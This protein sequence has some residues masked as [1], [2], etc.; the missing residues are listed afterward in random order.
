M[1]ILTILRRWRTEIGISIG[2]IALILALGFILPVGFVKQLCASDFMPHGNCYLWKPEILWLHVGSDAVV[3]LSYFAIP[4]CLVLLVKKRK[5]MKF[6]G[7]FWLFSL[8]I[9]FCGLSHLFEIYSVWHGAYRLAGTVKLLTA[10]ASLS[11]AVYLIRSMP[12]LS[13]L[14]LKKEFQAM[15]LQLSEREGL[16]KAILSGG[17]EGFVTI[18]PLRG[19]ND[20]IV[21]FRVD[22]F[23]AIAVQ[24]MQV[25]QNE[26]HGKSID[27][28]FPFAAK[29]GLQRI[30]RECHESKKAFHSEFELEGP[31]GELRWISFKVVPAGP[32][33][34]VCF[35]DV[36]KERQ[37]EKQI[38][39][40][41]EERV[42]RALEERDINEARAQAAMSAAAH[43]I[44]V[45]DSSGRIVQCNKELLTF[46]G[47]T[48][49]ELLGRSV[50]DL[51][52]MNARGRHAGHVHEFDEKPARRPMGGAIQKL[53]GLRK[54]G[55]TFPVEIGLN[56]FET[57][58]GRFVCASVVDI[59]ERI[60]ARAALQESEL[61]LQQA[62]S[63]GN[64][65]VWHWFDVTANEEYWSDKMYEL[66][67]YDREE[68]ESNYENFK[69]L[70]HPD[71]LK[72]TLDS[73]KNSFE[74][75]ASFEQDLRLLT[76]SQGYR[77]FC[78]AGKLMYDEE[79]GKTRMVGSIQDIQK[80]KDHEAE[81]ELV[82]QSLASKNLEMEEMTY[83]VSHDL[84]APLVSIQGLANLLKAD[85]E[86]I[87]DDARGLVG[88]IEKAALHMQ[89]MINDLLEMSRVGSS[90]ER[91]EWVD[92]KEELYELKEL[93]ESEIRK[94]NCT[95]H[96]DTDFPKIWTKRIL[97]RQAAQNLV[98]NA[99]KYGCTATSPEVRV[100]RRDGEGFVDLVFEDNGVG[101]P[102]ESQQSVFKLFRR[103]DRSIEGSGLGLAIVAKIMATLDGQAFVEDH[104]G[105][106]A[107]FVLRFPSRSEVSGIVRE[108][109]WTGKTLRPTPIEAASVS[110]GDLPELDVS[111]H[112]KKFVYATAHDF[113]APLVTIKGHLEFL[114]LH[115]S[116]RL[117]PEFK[118][119]VEQ[120]S[121]AANRMTDYLEALVK[122]GEAILDHKEVGSVV[123]DTGE[124]LEEILEKGRQSG[125]IDGVSIRLPSLPSVQCVSVDLLRTL[126]ENLFENAIRFARQSDSPEVRIS[127]EDTGTHWAFAIQDNGPGLGAS[128]VRSAFTPFGRFGLQ[129]VNKAGIGLAT[130]KMIVEMHR[131][132][133]WIDPD[134]KQGAKVRF[135]LER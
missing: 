52:P 53:F 134:Y 1:P 13:K 12:T 67:G 92:V 6:R 114:Q 36:S 129:D 21:E 66:I 15:E 16:F 34:A 73:L 68:L 79:T 89:G 40:A 11:T 81:I 50:E 14:P 113:N 2:V 119:L 20:E 101:I 9:L 130:C 17:L 19:E 122:Y 76:K 64:V 75:E 105:E 80:R 133:I 58:E 87:N 69:N 42:A 100:Y 61:R 121:I 46:F 26:A 49:S 71:D 95:L 23:N 90:S 107:R 120:S 59:T 22:E 18:K 63:G 82:N 99:L 128:D 57:T 94:R 45:V 41:L 72:S 110:R 32:Q 104:E 31:E 127:V 123:V 55:S 5:G 86:G 70:L 39:Q 7:V 132:Q 25:E 106:G 10:V 51:V 103:L 3:A 124:L 102:K 37:T 125:E 4:V 84:K 30:A 126:F 65:G 115:G 83:A 28:V 111:E 56:P 78:S 48:E 24:E 118:K 131:G 85:C 97:L 77:W 47:Y 35:M 93:F 43:G 108:D 117:E 112:F 135:T 88:R 33:L 116:E 54:D 109:T 62:T 96:L 44:L 98:S 60:K 38:Q 29:I 27:E 91:D 74:K 8:F